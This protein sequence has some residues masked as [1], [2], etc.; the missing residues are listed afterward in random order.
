VD[1]RHELVGWL[2]AGS[3]WRYSP[4]R[5]ARLERIADILYRR[6]WANPPESRRHLGAVYGV[7]PARIG[8]LERLG[9]GL[10]RQPPRRWA[11]R[12]D[13]PTALRRAVFGTVAG[14]PVEHAG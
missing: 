5:Q 4:S 14:R 6:Y 9:L 13:M 2:I 10:L 11:S 7:T 1:V 12:D 8:Q 3:R